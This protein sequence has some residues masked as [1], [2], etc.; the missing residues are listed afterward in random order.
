MGEREGEQRDDRDSF[1]RIAADLNLLRLEAGEVSYAEIVRR[2]GKHREAGGAPPTAARPARTTVYD[3]FR[4]GRSRVNA[5]LVGEI[6]RALGAGA[7]EVTRWEQRCI[8]ARHDGQ[9]V[10]TAPPPAAAPSPAT[11]PAPAP[12]PAPDPTPRRPGAT[13]SLRLILAC[14]VL[15][16]TGHAAVG[17]LALPLYLD[18]V[19]TAVAAIVLGP[20]HGVAVAVLT[21]VLGVSV[22]GPMALPFGVVNVAGALVWGF[23]ARSAR[24]NRSLPR[25]FTLNAL[26]AVVCTVVAAPLLLAL[27]QGETGHAGDSLT[28]TFTTMGEPL[29][30]AVFQ[31]NLFTSVVDKLIAGFFVL[32]V[33][34]QVRRW[35]RPPLDP[36]LLSA[37]FQNFRPLVGTGPVRPAVVA[38]PAH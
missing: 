36:H 17:W 8:R 23:G 3:A 4:T 14:L 12:T 9:R 25:Y 37:P 31:A 1:D 20:W 7:D 6:V 21:N 11:D 15:N 10:R 26:T 29:V 2:V 24:F 18:M 34:G 33:L 32:A 35:I 5:Q 28:H 16:Y 27:F 19:G 22:N 38:R 30:L 13:A